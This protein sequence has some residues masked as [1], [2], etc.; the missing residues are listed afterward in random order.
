MIRKLSLTPAPKKKEVY[1]AESDG[2]PLGENGFHVDCTLTLYGMLQDHFRRRRPDIH[3]ACDM[4]FYYEEGNPKANKAPD[5][6]VT[7]GIGGQPRRTFKT[8]VEKAIPCTIFETVSRQTRRED[9]KEKP[10]L[11]A[12]LGVQEYFLFDCIGEA[13]LRPPFQAFRLQKGLYVPMKPGADGGFTS[14]ELKLHFVPEGHRLRIIDLDAGRPLLFAWELAE[15]MEEEKRRAEE[16]KRRADALQAELEQL[17]A[18][19]KRGKKT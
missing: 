8:W 2:K 5:V 15:Q 17:R 10:I 16:E 19:R 12:R 14:R 1:Y 18:E 6:M 7:K 11:Y 4:F 13:R 3:V 9:T